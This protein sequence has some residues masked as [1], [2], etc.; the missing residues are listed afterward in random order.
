MA[1]A[2]FTTMTSSFPRIII[3][4]Y[5]SSSGRAKKQ[6]GNGYKLR[7]RSVR[8]TGTIQ[9]PCPLCTGFVYFL[10]HTQPPLTHTMPSSVALNR[11]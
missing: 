7:M 6:G 5:V 4:N 10:M 3:K 11:N 9:V 1:R 2:N 8:N